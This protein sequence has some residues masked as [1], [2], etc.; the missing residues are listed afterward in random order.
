MIELNDFYNA[1]FGWICRH[2]E[3]ELSSNGNSSGSTSRIFRE[4]EAESKTPELANAA[5]AQWMDKTQQVLI[6]PRCK[7]T[8]P[9]EK[10]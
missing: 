8:E 1:G 5:L 6:C 7:I 10:S 2:C 4:G 9:V 3:T